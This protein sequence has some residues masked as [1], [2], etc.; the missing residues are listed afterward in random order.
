MRSR[1]WASATRERQVRLRV[2]SSQTGGAGSRSVEEVLPPLGHPP[3]AN[4]RCSSS[5]RLR[6]KLVQPSTT[7]VGEAYSKQI[8]GLTLFHPSAP[9]LVAHPETAVGSCVEL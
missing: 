3:S 6:S 5:L 1:S 8:G 4:H 2:R 7:F 9:G